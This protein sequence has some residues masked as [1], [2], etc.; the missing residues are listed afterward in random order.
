MIDQSDA[1][2]TY[3][4]FW[5]LGLMIVF[6]NHFFVFSKVQFAI[7]ISPFVLYFLI[8]NKAMKSLTICLVLLFIWTVIHIFQ[9]AN[10]HFILLSFLMAICTLIYI[11][12]FWEFYSKVISFDLFIDFITKSNAIFLAIALS[13]YKISFLKNLFWYYNELSFKGNPIPRLKMFELEASHYSLTIAPLAIYYFWKNIKKYNQKDMLLL[14]SLVISLILSFSLGVLSALILAF[15][16]LFVLRTQKIYQYRRIKYTYISIFFIGTCCTAL[17]HFLYPDN[18]IFL[19]LKN[20]ITG[21]DTSGRGRTYEAF[22]LADM[23]VQKKN[24][25]LGIGLGQLKELGRTTIINYYS[26]TKIP[27]VVRLPNSLAETIVYFGYLGA[28]LKLIIVIF[29]FFKYKVYESPFNLSLYLFIF[30]Y[31]FTGSY[32]FNI[33]E[34]MIWII[35]IKPN[36][37]CLQFKNFEA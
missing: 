14:S 6:F 22:I 10:F 27:E 23:I 31:Q 28:V 29:L 17:L 35:A 30:I 11:S 9:G 34:Y 26:Y 16:T 24:M 19:R 18:L 25:F 7:I 12:F 8:K 13:A 37:F 33:A 21:A 20:V 4:T 32:I 36:Q 15:S 1:N 2:R 5:G 3:N